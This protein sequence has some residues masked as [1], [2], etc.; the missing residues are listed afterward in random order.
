MHRSRATR[1]VASADTGGK[2]DDWGVIMSEMV[3]LPAPSGLGGGVGIRAG[4]AARALGM[5]G[6]FNA[7]VSLASD[8]RPA[9][10]TGEREGS[11]F[12]EIVVTARKRSENLR[13]TPA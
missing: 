5:T 8:D 1:A 3:R 13:D 6:V 2:N 10:S 11:S 4:L 7:P 12:D 9:G